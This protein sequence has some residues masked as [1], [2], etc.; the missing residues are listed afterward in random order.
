MSKKRYTPE[1]IIPKIRTDE[2]EVSKEIKVSLACNKIG[3][4]EQTHYRCRKEYDGLRLY[5]AK[6]LKEPEK[7]NGR[8]KKFLA[9]SEEDE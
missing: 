3:V 7:V 6:P 2:T 1:Q 9:E 5:Q 4:T 8:L